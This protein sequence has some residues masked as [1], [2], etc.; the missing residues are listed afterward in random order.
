MY[1]L[2][3]LSLL[4][5][6]LRRRFLF[7]GFQRTSANHPWTSWDFH[8]AQLITLSSQ[9]HYHIPCLKKNAPGAECVCVCVCVR[10]CMCVAK[11]PNERG[12][13]LRAHLRR[14]NCANGL[15]QWKRTGEEISVYQEIYNA[16]S[17][18]KRNEVV[19][20]SMNISSVPSECVCA[21]TS[22]RSQI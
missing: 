6:L 17:L 1:S 4:P 18:G 19:L 22:P 7:N 5:P 15:K 20:F 21:V 10:S 3:P 13:I 8:L 14:H 16:T 11:P 12:T 2:L 9:G